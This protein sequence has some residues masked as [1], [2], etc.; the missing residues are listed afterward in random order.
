M[1][2][3]D[4]IC[5]S[6]LIIVIGGFLIYDVSMGYFDSYVINFIIVVFLLIL[7]CNFILYYVVFVMGGVY[8][9]YYWCDFEFC[10]FFVI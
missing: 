10:V 6:F 5:Y 9:K 3:F 8:F 2:L 7:L 1:S 4:V